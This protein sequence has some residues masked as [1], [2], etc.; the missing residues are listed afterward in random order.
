VD[1]FPSHIAVQHDSELIARLRRRDPAAAGE[2]YE[3]YG[4][5]LFALILNIVGDRQDTEDL[6]AELLL[7]VS[8]RLQ[9]FKTNDFA[10]RPWLLILARN[11]ALQFRDAAVGTR[12]RAVGSDRLESPAL[13][14]TRHASPDKAD[15]AAT[16]SAFLKLAD[17]DRLILELAW[18]EGM[19][20]DEIASRIGLPIAEV[21]AA[22][23]ASLN[24]IREC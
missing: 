22:A 21:T 19:T 7:K 24:R 13:F 18:F 23:T 8:N 12:E 11:H 16:Q 6:L 5:L 3:R 10:L 4:K 14:S 15:K 9:G 2:L 17:I 20:F 1:W